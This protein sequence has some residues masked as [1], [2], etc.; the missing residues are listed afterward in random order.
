MST[1]QF[2]FKSEDGNEYG[3]ITAEEIR[4][5]QAQGRMNSESLVRYTNSREWLPLSSY[6]ELA[7]APPPAPAQESE[8]EPAPEPAPSP[9]PFASGQSSIHT[10]Q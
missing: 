6:D 8:P 3:P 10:E 5:W 7:T 4:D 9:S 2:Y 1:R